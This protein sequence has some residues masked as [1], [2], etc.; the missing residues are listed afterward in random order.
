MRLRRRAGLPSCPRLPR[1]L[2][3]LGRLGRRLGWQLRCFAVPRAGGVYPL[4]FLLGQQRRAPLARRAVGGHMVQPR[5]AVGK[6]ATESAAHLGARASWDD[7][8]R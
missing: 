1:L 6:D 8:S 7:A 2:A 3:R 5:V 4:G